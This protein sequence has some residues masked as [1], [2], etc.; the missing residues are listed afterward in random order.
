M[1]RRA[2]PAG[3]VLAALVADAAGRH[4]VALAVVLCAIPAAAAKALSWYG[5][6]LEARC[7]GVRPL[8]AG[9]AALL[10][11]FS[12]AL[13]SPAVVGGTPQLALSALVCCLLLYAAIAAASLAPLL[14]ERALPAGSRG[15]R[16][17]GSGR[18]RYEPVPESV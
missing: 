5:D 14:A 7:G 16:S 12:A 15:R 11:V 17:P 6:A 3:L 10:V 4:G 1:I 18:E 8:L 9:L 13:R 2:L